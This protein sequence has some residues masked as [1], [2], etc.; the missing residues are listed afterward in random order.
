MG[1][2][3]HCLCVAASQHHVRLRRPGPASHGVGVSTKKVDNKGVRPRWSRRRWARATQEA[4]ERR[5]RR[6]EGRR[7]CCCS[8]PLARSHRYD[9]PQLVHAATLLRRSKEG[10]WRRASNDWRYPFRNFRSLVSRRMWLRWRSRCDARAGGRT[11]LRACLECLCV[12]SGC[13]LLSNSFVPCDAQFF[14]IALSAVCLEN[15]MSEL[16][17]VAQSPHRH[18]VRA[19]MVSTA[20]FSA[21]F[22]S[23]LTM[24]SA[25]HSSLC[26][27]RALRRS[28]ERLAG[29][30]ADLGQTWDKE[31]Q[32][33]VHCTGSRGPNAYCPTFL[34][35]HPHR[36]PCPICS[37]AWPRR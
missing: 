33:R 22:C 2:H 19:R 23:Q 26:V 7:R 11:R 21:A 17:G 18:R 36:A 34:I 30:R 6:L 27:R 31:S 8:R 20:S 37:L 12:H 5:L 16:A 25:W 29:P 13:R 35:L 10:E 15:A 28:P 1:R 3:W 14:L 4:T 24:P 9:R 32:D